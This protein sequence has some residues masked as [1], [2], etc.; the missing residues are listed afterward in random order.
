M[1]KSPAAF[2]RSMCH[3]RCRRI[4]YSSLLPKSTV[5][6]RLQNVSSRA[7]SASSLG[8]N[9]SQRPLDFIS[10]SPP[11]KR[12]SST[13]HE[14]RDSDGMPPVDDAEWELRVG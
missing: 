5:P 2:P 1:R 13:S 11:S 6:P 3:S 9:Y 14:D 8:V 10:N 12:N 4:S 7:S